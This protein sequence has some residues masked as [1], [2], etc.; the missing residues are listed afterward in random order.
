MIGTRHAAINKDDREK[1]WNHCKDVVA[2]VPHIL[3][4][5]S[6]TKKKQFESHEYICG[7]IYIAFLNQHRGYETVDNI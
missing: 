3:L 6:I 4:N 5:C 1:Y 2:S 7:G